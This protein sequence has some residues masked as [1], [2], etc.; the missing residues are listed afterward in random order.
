MEES[1]DMFD[2]PFGRYKA[3]SKNRMEDKNT[4]YQINQI[5]LFSKKSNFTFLGRVLFC[6]KIRLILH[7]RIKKE[8]KKDPSAKGADVLSATP[9]LARPVRRKFEAPQ[10]PAA[11]CMHLDP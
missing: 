6:A 5:G 7:F 1:I 8:D 11:E 10:F 2:F 4:I 3:Q 9:T